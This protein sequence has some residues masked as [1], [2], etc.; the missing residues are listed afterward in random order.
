MN[1]GIAPAEPDKDITVSMRS[2][3]S[4]KVG[5]DHEAVRVGREG[6]NL[7]LPQSLANAFACG[8]DKFDLDVGDGP[9]GH[10][11]DDGYSEFLVHA[12]AFH[13]YLPVYFFDSWMAS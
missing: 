7:K 1:V 6:G 2:G 11:I 4:R 13:L 5:E 9:P 12:M 3:P 10:F 8:C